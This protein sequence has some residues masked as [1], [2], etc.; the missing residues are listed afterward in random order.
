MA[1]TRDS[2]LRG[3]VTLFQ[4]ERGFRSSLDPV[5]LAAFVAAPYGRFLDVGCGTGALSF[6][7]LAR[8]PA[9]IG[10]GVELQPALAALVGQGSAANGFVARFTV[11]TGDVRSTPL[12]DAAFDLVA[13]NP[14]FR[15][16]GRGPLPPDPGRAAAHHEVALTLADWLDVAAR[17]LR[18][19]GRLA[20]IFPAGRQHD[21]LEGC[22]RRGL[23]PSRKRLVLP[24][25]GEP[26]NRILLEAR[27]GEGALVEEPPL[28]VHEDGGYTAEVRR[29]LGEL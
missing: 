6:L 18:P 17:V 11:V 7:L 14:P 12:P 3:R 16:L 2:L 24:R 28:V 22:R 25:A 23:A 19:Q 27:R 15:P 10:V 9:A 5:L 1:P 8:D 29:F 4:P 26:E 21:L 20:V 13:T